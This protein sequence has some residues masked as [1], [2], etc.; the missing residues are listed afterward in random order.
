MCIVAYLV[1]L[2]AM[3]DTIIRDFC[4]LYDNKVNQDEVLVCICLISIFIACGV[5]KKGSS[6]K[7]KLIVDIFNRFSPTLIMV[8]TVLF[9]LSRVLDCVIMSIAVVLLFS[10]F[11]AI[12]IAC[13][14]KSYKVYV[15][16]DK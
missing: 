5:N 3:I 4:A 16:E 12:T 1:S 13:K 8:S 10:V 14:Y 15:S 7:M 2:F 6:V 11:L 9:Y